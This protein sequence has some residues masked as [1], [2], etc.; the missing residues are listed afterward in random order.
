MGTVPIVAGVGRPSYPETVRDSQEFWVEYFC[1]RQ[2]PYWQRGRRPIQGYGNATNL[3]RG[4][5]PPNGLARV[6]DL[7]GRELYRV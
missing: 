1:P 2:S 6:L 3:A 4:M 5:R 7:A